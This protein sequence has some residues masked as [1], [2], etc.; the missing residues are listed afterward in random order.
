MNNELFKVN[1]I[2][3]STYSPRQPYQ[4]TRTLSHKHIV[5]R[6]LHQIQ[7]HRVLLCF[8]VV[9]HRFL[10]FLLCQMPVYASNS[11]IPATRLGCLRLWLV[12][13]LIGLALKKVQLSLLVM[14]PS[15]LLNSCPLHGWKML[16]IEVLEA[17]LLCW[18]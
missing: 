15:Y 6:P 5:H 8:Q 12:L 9:G 2:L 4:V 7:L 10:A 13:M 3:Y 14:L 1:F 16:K 17:G 18:C 11:V